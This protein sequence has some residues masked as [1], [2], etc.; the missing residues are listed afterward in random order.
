[1]S[2]LFSLHLQE[3]FQIPHNLWGH[4]WYKGFGPAMTTLGFLS[5]SIIMGTQ[6]ILIYFSLC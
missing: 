4:L 2:F 6:Q 5:L 3:A 1:M